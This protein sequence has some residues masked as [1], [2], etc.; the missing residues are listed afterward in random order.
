[1]NPDGSEEQGPR[2]P[3][4]RVIR[5]LAQSA[6][7][8]LAVAAILLSVW[9][10]VENRRHNRLSVQPRIDGSSQVSDEDGLWRQAFRFSSDGLGPAA[11]TEFRV[12]WQGLETWNG[13]APAAA[14]GPW[15]PVLDR[16]SDRFDLTASSLGV[17]SVLRVGEDYQVLL[18]RQRSAGSI[19]DLLDATSAIGV[20]L[21]YCSLYGDQCRAAAIGRTPIGPSTCQAD[22]LLGGNGEP[23]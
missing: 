9:E 7:G 2:R 21:C 19:G 13:R 8:A 12:Y 10:G 3:G 17:G 23:R 1:M 18:V 16:L 22:G 4:H 14:S 20:L 6:A 11:V 5:G 15:Q